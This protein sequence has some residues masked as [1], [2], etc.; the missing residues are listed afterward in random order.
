MIPDSGL[1]G[2]CCSLVLSPKSLH[3]PLQAQTPLTSHI[4]PRPSLPPSPALS[5][6]PPHSVH[7]IS[8]LPRPRGEGLLPRSVLPDS[9]LEP[10][11]LLPAPLDAALLCSV[12]RRSALRLQLL[13]HREHSGKSCSNST[14]HLKLQICEPSYQVDT[15]A[16][17]SC[18]HLPL[19]LSVTETS[20]ASWHPFQ[21]HCLC[22][23]ISTPYLM[24]GLKNICCSACKAP[25]LQ[26]MS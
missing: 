1:R 9:L 11:R 7:Q 20:S 25:Q 17:A 23:Y 5:P 2:S 12:L 14:P 10:V 8:L 21:A 6:M 16:R 15:P 18:Q 24:P 4:V 3:L 19:G 26:A 13:T 22:S